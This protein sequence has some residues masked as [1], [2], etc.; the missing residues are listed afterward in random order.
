LEIA[1]K[2]PIEQASRVV[3]VF[4][5][6]DSNRDASLSASEMKAVFSKL[7]ISDEALLK[8]TFKALDL[9]GDGVLSF[10]EFTAGVLLLFKDILDDGLQSLFLEH[11]RDRDGAINK[12][13]AQSL[14]ARA[15]HVARRRPDELLGK[16]FPNERTTIRYGELRQHI[17]GDLN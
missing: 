3:D 15:S 9:D 8:K 4:E 10:S 16:L 6:F 17:L 2:L 7:G 11:D 13:E 1:A 5:T 12:H 14:L